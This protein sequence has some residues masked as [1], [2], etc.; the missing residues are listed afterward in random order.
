MPFSSPVRNRLLLA[1]QIL[2]PIAIVAVAII[3]WLFFK[4]SSVRLQT[5]NELTRLQEIMRSNSEV[6]SL[7]KDL[8][9][10]Q[11]GYLLSGDKSY[12]QPY[13]NAKD[14]LPNAVENLYAILQLPIQR[15][16]I[17]KLR[18]LVLEKTTEIEATLLIRDQLGDAVA[19]SIFR[20]NRGK[21]TMDELRLLSAEIQNTAY[22][23]F[24]TKSQEMEEESAKALRGIMAACV[25]LVFELAFSLFLIQR[26][27]MRR[28]DLIDRLEDA[29]LRALT[30]L[31]S[32]GDGVITAD[33]TG[34]V[35]Y[36]NPVASALTGWKV[37]DAVG[38]SIEQ[39]CP[40]QHELTG[41]V[42]E[43]P[44]RKVVQT[45]VPQMLE[46]PAYLIRQDGSRLIVDD[47]AAPIFDHDNQLAGIVM[48]FRDM[49]QRKAS[50][51]AIKRWQQVFQQAGFGMAIFKPGQPPLIDELNQAFAQLHNYS[52]EELKGQSLQKLVSPESWKVEAAAFESDH[53]TLTESLHVRKDGSLFP[54]LLD[55]S[56]VRDENGNAIY[57]T[58][59]YSD[60]SERK[61]IESEILWSEEQY[62]L[63]ADSMAQ[64]V[65]TSKAD[66][67]TEYMNVKWQQQPRF[68]EYAKDGLSWS[69]F[70]YP[71]DRDRC[72]QI[73]K[74]SME[75]GETFQV[76]C[77]IQEC[78]EKGP[79]WHNCRAFPIRDREGRIRRWFGSC[80]DVHEQW[81]SAEALRSGKEEM[82]RMNR[83]LLR[84]NQDLEQ[85]AYV[86]SHDLQEPLRMVVIYSKLLQQ[87][88][89]GQLT[90][91]A[92]DY[93]TFAV[94][95]A[96]RMEALLKDLLA[97]S[98]ASSQEE[99]LASQTDSTQD[100]NTAIRNLALQIDETYATIQFEDL[101]TSISISSVHLTQVFQNLLS[102]AMKYRKP[103]MPPIIE[104]NAERN[105]GIWVFRIKDNGIGIALGYQE[106][107][108]RI[109]GRLHGQDQP[110]TGIGLALCKKL[111]ERNGGRIW[112]KSELGEGSTFLFSVPV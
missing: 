18:S 31:S 61:R 37:E 101:P 36:L 78:V 17:Q 14:T 103:D 69:T 2:L 102:N 97:Y 55:V 111:I 76:D 49:T 39:I 13:Q 52:L 77:R 108:F 105:G 11:R 8:E 3:G 64:L 44:V 63:T 32:I 9:S 30:T 53:H 46:N 100:L 42:L 47:S 27:S 15:E 90:Q 96:K 40:L 58:A 19:I 33:K 75:S 87:E 107:I 81:E 6:L 7:L 48:V 26:A 51:D 67:S 74:Q 22:E 4:D 88:L 56:V 94:E 98:R 38:K 29:R 70:L 65:W 59:S 28:E 80:T 82:E 85:F 89:D 91:Q 20:S 23:N 25:L 35:S 24:K 66:G 112:V 68:E 16:R 41:S 43:N 71:E 95:G 84:S 104:V 50:S 62:R 109:F 92:N 99:I 5:R 21:A 110:G 79:R 73:W 54:V 1:E 57:S 10:G 72:M 83:A 45:L 106:Q 34:L 93:M 60:I 86:A 12:L